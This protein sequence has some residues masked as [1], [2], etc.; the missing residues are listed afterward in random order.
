M[1][2]YTSCSELLVEIDQIIDST[3]IVW[4]A[5]FKQNNGVCATFIE[6]AI[7]NCALFRHLYDY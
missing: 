7:C 4:V 1:Q 5:Y 3:A 6:I 2:I